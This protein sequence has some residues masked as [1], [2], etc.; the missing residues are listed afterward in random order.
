MEDASGLVQ[1]IAALFAL[2]VAAFALFRADQQKKQSAD[3]ARETIKAITNEA[4]EVIVVD[5]E[6]EHEEV[7]AAVE[8]DDPASEVAALLNERRPRRRGPT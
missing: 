8:S 5:A 4:H 3:K 1:S 7:T 6:E 2:I